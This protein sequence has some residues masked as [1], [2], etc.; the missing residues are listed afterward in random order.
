LVTGIRC[1]DHVLADEFGDE[2]G[3]I[4]LWR[5]ACIAASKRLLSVAGMMS[6]YPSFVI[7]TKL[8]YSAVADSPSPKRIGAQDPGSGLL[9]ESPQLSG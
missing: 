7:V 5:N 9:H 3:D 2:N 4:R 1:S 6:P 8:K